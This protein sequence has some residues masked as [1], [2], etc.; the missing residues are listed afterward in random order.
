MIAY[1]AG[2]LLE[3]HTD[4]VTLL[5][6]DVG[7]RVITTAPHGPLWIHAITSETGTRLYGFATQAEREAFTALLAVDGIGPKTAQAIVAAGV[8]HM[9]HLG[10][11]WFVKQTPQLSALTA[12]KGVGAKTAAKILEALC[13]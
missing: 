12:V 13:A 10:E 9:A 11:R 6:G 8:L 4:G 2:E 5:A 3:R 7:Y 1:L